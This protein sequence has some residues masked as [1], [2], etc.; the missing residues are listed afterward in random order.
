MSV[1]SKFVSVFKPNDETHVNWLSKM[2]DL[3]ENW[4]KF[5]VQKEMAKN[6]MK[7]PIETK[8]VLDWPHVHFCLC[9]VYAKAVLKGQAHIPPAHKSP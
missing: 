1:T 7:V 4:G 5:D 6:P 9:A 8:D 2:C 3:A